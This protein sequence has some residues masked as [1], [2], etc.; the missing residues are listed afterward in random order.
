MTER[1]TNKQ[2]EQ[3]VLSF[4]PK[5]GAAL[6]AVIILLGS[7]TTVGTGELVRVQNNITGGNSWY[8]T[9]GV[10]MKVPFFSNVVT[11]SQEYTIAITDNEELCDKASICGRNQDILFADTY[12][13]DLETSYRFSLPR[14][15]EQLEVMHDKVKN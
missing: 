1:M 15:P 2:I 5:A 9:E 3:K 12:G 13:I 4:L 7:F 14:L 6:L 10:K 8:T 11:Y